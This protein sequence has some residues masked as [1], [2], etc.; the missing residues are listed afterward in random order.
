[1]AKRPIKSSLASNNYYIGI[2][3][4][5]KIVNLSKHLESYSFNTEEVSIR[6]AKEKDHHPLR[7]ID[8]NPT[9]VECYPMPLSS[10]HMDW[11]GNG[12]CEAKARHMDET[13]EA[14]KEV[15][16]S[17]NKINEITPF[18]CYSFL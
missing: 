5:I 3:N 1:M 7:T 2:E 4:L 14:Q 8:M 18:V 15:T 17:Q 12:V 16:C 6:T 10:V 11:Y 13:I 9:A